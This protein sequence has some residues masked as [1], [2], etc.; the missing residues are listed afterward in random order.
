MCLFEARA[1]DAIVFVGLFNL[2]LQK[3]FEKIN[4]IK[5]KIMISNE[6]G[7]I[8][9]HIIDVK[10][11]NSEFRNLGMVIVISRIVL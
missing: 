2:P 4:P 7:L 6:I 1:R 11:F 5:M 3:S 10:N 9:N 8:E